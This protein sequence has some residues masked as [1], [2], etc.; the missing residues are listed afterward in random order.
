MGLPEQ[1]EAGVARLESVD[2][3]ET[4][5]QRYFEAFEA[6]QPFRADDGDA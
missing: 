6:Q 1:D 2:V 5:V 4:T 3:E